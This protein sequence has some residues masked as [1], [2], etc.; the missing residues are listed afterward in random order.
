[1]KGKWLFLVVSIVFFT[2]CQAE[3]NAEP[4][5]QEEEST[6]TAAA[7]QF[8]PELYEKEKNV[9]A[10]LQETEKAFEN[11][12]DLVVA[13][14]MATTGYMYEE[15]EDI[16]PFV[17]QIPGETTEKFSELTKEYDGHIVFGMPEEEKETE[18]YY[19]SA[20]L[21]GP[22]GY[23]GKY[24]KTQM[25]ETEMHWGAWGDLGVPVFDTE[26]GRIAINICMDSAY[27][28][29]ARLAGIKDADI[30]A[31][32]TNSS[33]QAISS[34][35][36]RAQQNGMYVVSA[37]RSNTEKGFHM[38]GGSAVW[39][40][41]GEKLAE[42]PVVMEEEEAIEET[43]I[44]YA[45]IEQSD[46]ENDNKERVE[47]R[48]PELYKELGQR[49]SPWDETKN[50]DEKNITTFT[51]QYEPKPGDKKSNLKKIEKLAVSAS[52]EE[53]F[54]LTVLPEMSLT[55]PLEN[56]KSSQ[57]RKLAENENGKT[58]QSMA[59]LAE[60]YNTAIVYGFIEKEGN[61]LFNSA[62]LLDENGE[63]AGK[64]RKSHLSEEDKEWAAAGDKLSVFETDT[65]G[66][67]GLL[68]GEDALYPETAGGSEP[69]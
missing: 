63:K 60:K 30:L 57:L 36:A 22:D 25:W 49:I 51:P 56:E 59:K 32:P 20:V 41:Q 47:E 34:L 61:S 55:G 66:K 12:A 44:E 3:T 35:P 58:M 28:E 21:I 18:L 6:I 69:C 38:V 9:D 37:N 31:F 40:P 14:E 2:G 46:Y 23:M 50:T 62:M 5:P 43:N 68:I 17:E 11:G 53:D 15:R 29:P 7:I 19:N 10:L 16:A 45:E 26:I 48:R 52:Q 64:Y 33:A 54:K 24:R 27:V 1:M 65:L 4:E 13:P 8:N 42:A 39:S 67:I